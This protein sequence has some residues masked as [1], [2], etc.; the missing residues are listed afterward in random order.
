MLNIDIFP[1]YIIAYSYS[2]L[3]PDSVLFITVLTL[4]I[5]MA[6]NNC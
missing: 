2:P 6:K 1:A 5:R 4:I 3:L